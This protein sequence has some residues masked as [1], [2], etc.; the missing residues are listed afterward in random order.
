MPLGVTLQGACVADPTSTGPAADSLAH[1]PISRR[2]VAAAVIGNALEFYDFTTYTIF[3]VDIGACFFPSHSHFASLMLSLAAFGAGFITRP[4]G[5]LVIGRLAD[6]VGRR[7]A[8]LLSFALM[9]LAIVTLASTP[10]YASIGVAAPIIAVTCRLV[11]GFALGGEVGPVMAFLIEAA[12]PGR[13]GYLGSWQSAS[14]SVASLVGGV[15]GAALAAVLSVHMLE[16]YGWR[17]AFWIGALVLPFG[18]IV[19]RTLPETLHRPET[20]SI[21]HPETAHLLSHARIVLLGMAVIVC[22]TTSTYVRLFLTTYAVSTLQMSHAAA[23]GASAVN[24]AAGVVFTLL[25]G[26]L[27][28]RYGRKPAMIAPLIVYL[29]AIYPAFYL[30]VR[31]H[32]LASLWIATGVISALSSMSTGAALI[33]LTEG[34]RKE[35]RSAGMGTLY[36]VTVA[37]FGGGTQ[38]LLEWM[39]HATRQP[40][41]LAIYLMATTVIGLAAMTAMR[42]TA[43]VRL[44]ARSANRA[45]WSKQPRRS[46]PGDLSAGP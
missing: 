26:A 36:A 41:S 31:N 28:D 33:W 18:L 16:S 4:I 7:P 30:M 35:I 17:A 12:P 40:M 44:D 20:P 29:F 14:Q 38:P 2:Q 32:D 15:V 9:G 6:R 19:R 13:R 25:G 23:Y 10:S 24:G 22:F 3:A 37:V 5:A 21:A 46:P 1:P 39:I 27:S 43:P 34:F 45:A 8:M 11:Q 42:E